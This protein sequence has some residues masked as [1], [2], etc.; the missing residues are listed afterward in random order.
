MKLLSIVLL[1]ALL[2]AFISAKPIDG[3]L[4]PARPEQQR[5]AKVVELRKKLMRNKVRLDKN[6][7]PCWQYTCQ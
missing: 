4:Q 7:K 5:N 3:E 1:L 2:L 6:G